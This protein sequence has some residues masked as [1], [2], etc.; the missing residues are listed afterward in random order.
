M[1]PRT[2]MKHRVPVTARPVRTGMTAGKTIAATMRR[3]KMPMRRSV[4]RMALG[5]GADKHPEVGMDLAQMALRRLAV[6]DLQP[7]AED[8]KVFGI[9]PGARGEVVDM[10]VRHRRARV[11]EV[12]A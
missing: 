12:L 6:P 4:H 9:E 11:R 8:R 10:D 5:P 3:I 7:L 1:A 2:A